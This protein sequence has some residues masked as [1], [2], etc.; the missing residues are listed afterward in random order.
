MNRLEQN[1]D[2]VNVILETLGDLHLVDTDTQQTVL[3]LA[4]ESLRQVWE[5]E[6]VQIP[7]SLF[8]DES[9][10]A[11]GKGLVGHVWAGTKGSVKLAWKVAKKIW[12]ALIIA[13][14]T[15]N[16][17]MIKL[18]DR[19]ITLFSGRNR[20]MGELARWYGMPAD[21]KLLLGPI[22]ESLTYLNNLA[23]VSHGSVL[24]IL[25]TT[26]KRDIDIGA[27]KAS[28]TYYMRT[29]DEKGKWKVKY[30]GWNVGTLTSN[31]FNSAAENNVKILEVLDK[32]MY[33]LLNFM[34]EMEKVEKTKIDDVKKMSNTHKKSTD[35][36]DIQEVT[37]FKESIM[38]EIKE[39]IAVIIKRNADFELGK[40]VP[41]GD[42]GYVFDMEVAS[43]KV[44]EAHMRHDHPQMLLNNVQSLLTKL[45]KK[46]KKLNKMLKKRKPNKWESSRTVNSPIVIKHIA[47]TARNVI[48][49]F[50]KILKV[51]GKV[52][53]KIS[54]IFLSIIDSI[55]TCGTKYR[56]KERDLLTVRAMKATR[57]DMKMH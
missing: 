34:M 21:K 23:F 44:Y 18:Q 6:N 30:R 42:D 8:S 12:N 36:K 20:L 19:V 35:S 29:S 32:D 13:T 27:D 28:I 56:Q 47:E 7:F 2:K 11:E 50:N 53:K 10:A 1:I 54:S 33:H 4:N 45:N 43:S 41:Q 26:V 25:E 46:H 49:Y 15:L 5:E 40:L 51:M 3:T 14:T 37:N 22:K 31:D 52:L 38:A 55:A 24:A 48:T 9:L 16:V 17:L 57:A 39:E